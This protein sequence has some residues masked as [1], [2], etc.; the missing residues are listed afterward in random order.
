LSLPLHGDKKDFRYIYALSSWNTGPHAS[1]DLISGYCEN[2][3]LL[4]N[5]YPDITSFIGPIVPININDSVNRN[6]SFTDSD[7][8][9]I[10]TA[11]FYWD[12]NG[13]R[14]IYSL[15]DVIESLGVGT[16]TGSHHYNEPGVYTLKLVITDDNQESDSEYFQFVVVY[17][18]DNG[19]VTGGGWIMSPEGAYV[20]D[21]S[22]TGNATFGFV[23]KYKKGQTTPSG[24]TEFRFQAGNLNFHSDEYEWLVVTGSNYARLK[25]TG[26]ING[27]GS[28]KFMI[29]A[30]D[31]TGDDGTDTFRIRIWEEDVDGNETDVYDNDLDQ[32][33]GGGSIIVHAGE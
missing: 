31:G 17:D 32:S 13:D 3:A 1:G 30:G 21:P 28:Y 23:S 26:T 10:H 22:L 6:G 19:F 7:T 12:W 27:E 24:N 8:F 29:W 4:D 16:V 11:T 5:A 14:N 2:L 18:P 15:G 20:T 25:G 9:N 33:I